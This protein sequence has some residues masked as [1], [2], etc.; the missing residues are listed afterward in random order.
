MT[1]SSDSRKIGSEESRQEQARLKREK[2]QLDGRDEEVELSFPLVRQSSIYSLTLDEIQNAVCEPGKS[3]GSMNMDE[4]LANIWSVEEGQGNPPSFPPAISAPSSAGGAGGAGTGAGA[5]AG[6]LQRQ[7]SLTIPAPLS[8]KTV[9]EVWSEIH[10]GQQQQ[11]QQQKQQAFGNLNHPTAAN[12]PRQPTFGEMTLEDFLIK[13]GVVREGYNEPSPQTP[14]PAPMPT[15]TPPPYGLPSFQMGVSEAS[16]YSHV[17]GVGLGSAATSNGIYGSGYAGMT[18]GR[19]GGGGV[20]VGGGEMYYGGCNSGY[21]GGIGSPSSP[22]S[23]DGQVENVVRMEAGGKGGRKRA[24]D[25]A[26]EKVVER[27]QRRMIKNRESAARSRARKQA[28]T[29]ELEAELNQLKEENARLR[30]EERQVMELRKQLLIQTMADQSQ[31]TAHK[32]V[33]TLRQCKSCYW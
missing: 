24:A 21:S 27:R 10:R 18:N 16:G 7:G 25:G 8:R 2:H 19:R 4:L 6:G 33:P 26:V 20:G 28:Y 3:F 15:P 12:P 17:M 32:P 14:T 31:S 11:Q 30:E 13:A 5:G 1:S 29:V 22:V 23:S 9:D